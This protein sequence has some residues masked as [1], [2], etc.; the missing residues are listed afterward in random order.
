LFSTAG[1]DHIW[2]G[3]L[4]SVWHRSHATAQRKAVVVAVVVA[5]A[6]KHC[7][8]MPFWLSDD[9][10][11][12]LA[13]RPP[14]ALRLAFGA[15]TFLIR[16]LRS[17][18][19]F[20]PGTWHSLGFTGLTSPLPERQK[21]GRPPR[22]PP[23][24]EGSAMT[25]N[26]TPGGETAADTG[27]PESGSLEHVNPRDLVIGTNVRDDAAL[28]AEFIASIKEHGVL[29]PI[30]G[31]RGE[32]GQ[33]RV[34]Y[35]QRRTLA[36]READLPTVPVYIRSASDGNDT[37]QL[38]ERVS[39]QIV[40][41]DHR[42]ELTTNQRAKGIQQMLDAGV[43]VT[44]V[45]K[46]LAVDKDTVK[47]AGAAGKSQVAMEALATDQLSLAEAAVLAEFDDMP[48]AL[49]TLARVAGTASFDYTVERLRNQQASLKAER[50]AEAVWREKGFTVLEQV[51]DSW[52]PAYVALAFLVTASG[53]EA[54]ETVVTDPAQ[55]AVVLYEEDGWVDAETG[56]VVEEDAV[57]W[58]TQRA[59]DATPA[60]GLRHANTVNEASLFVPEYFCLDYNGAGLLPNERFQRFAG[61]TKLS[62]PADGAVDL[63]GDDT[64]DDEAKAAREAA[65]AQAVLDAERRERRKVIALNRLGEAAGVVRR[66]FLSTLVSRKTPPKGA[67][68]FVAD[69]LA[70]D[71]HMLTEH[72]GQHVTAAILGLDP[73]GGEEGAAIRALVTGLPDNGDARAQVII[74]A[75]VLGCLESRT[76]KD[77]W[78]Q[79][80]PVADLSEARWGWSF[81]M[82]S[83]DLLRYLADNGYALSPIEQVI[84]GERT[85]DEVYDEHLAEAKGQASGED[86]TEDEATDA[87]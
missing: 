5:K 6:Q 79:P 13:T 38:V 7:L 87:A 25:D 28:D 30:V 18:E 11:R 74:L 19:N 80:A 17:R 83:G 57:D 55:W 51:P 20:P 47:A 12:R 78:R 77:A 69:A 62:Q 72:N 58:D 66:Q 70:R 23:A 61:M 35:G 63:D 52:D 45:A 86:D 37:A 43:S 24:M 60:E 33:V 3:D 41:N 85:A 54:D 16:S 26:I 4:G 10:P 29:V 81:R 59:E 21:N 84:T 49:A 14:A 48:D 40:E 36:A 2:C 1:L 56:E 27:L 34:R 64:E 15:E 53:E 46:A 8:S 68:R 50:E 44:K 76:P 75:T 65:A 67:G 71:S 42:R 39:E 32:D 22:T 31:V 9:S 82:T 73:K